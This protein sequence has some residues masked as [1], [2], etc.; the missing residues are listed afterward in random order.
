M[1]IEGAIHLRSHNIPLSWSNRNTILGLIISWQWRKKISAQTQLLS[2]CILQIS[3]LRNCHRRRLYYE[4]EYNLV[5]ELQSHFSTLWCKGIVCDFFIFT[6]EQIL[7]I[8]KYCIS[9]K[10]ILKNYMPKLYRTCV[11]NCATLEIIFKTWFWSARIPIF[12]I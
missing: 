10:P 6:L 9:N 1:P 11:V 8:N 12:D 2:F 4:T 3:V 7:V 5:P